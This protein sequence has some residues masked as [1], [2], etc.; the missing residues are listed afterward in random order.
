MGNVSNG[1][2]IETLWAMETGGGRRQAV[3]WRRALNLLAYMG[4]VGKVRCEGVSDVNPEGRVL[5][6]YFLG[7]A[8][9]RA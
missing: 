3:F 6:G 2:D 8:L 7:K 1:E 5:R 4:H 9:S